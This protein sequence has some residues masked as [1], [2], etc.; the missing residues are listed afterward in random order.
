MQTALSSQLKVENS[1]ATLEIIGLML[2]SLKHGA[3]FRRPEKSMIGNFVQTGPFNILAL[4]TRNVERLGVET[5]PPPGV[6]VLPSN[7]L[8]GICRW[9]GS[10]FHGW[11]GY[12]WVAFIRLTR[13]GPHIFG[14]WGIRNFRLVGILKWQDF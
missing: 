13:M 6:R 9:M 12:Y 7:R 2:R 4:F 11:I 8:M 10:L 1:S 5:P 14:I 3:N